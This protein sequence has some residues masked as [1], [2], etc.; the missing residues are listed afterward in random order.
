MIEKIIIAHLYNPGSAATNR[1][2]AYASGYK[3]LGNS[4]SL[5]FGC[6]GGINA[7]NLDD[8][9]VV[10]V[11]SQTHRGLSKRMARV[12]KSLYDPSR[13]A[14]QIYGTPELCLYLPK[15][16]YNIFYECTEVPFYGEKASLPSRLKEVLRLWL[17]KRSTGMMVIS[18][19]LK[20]YYSD[21]GIKNIEIVNMF[22]DANRFQVDECKR[23]DEYI[24]YCGKVSLHKD[25]VDT[26]IRAYSVF[27]KNHS[28]V[29][30]WII[31]GFESKETEKQVRGLSKELN[32][33]RDVRFLGAVAP[34]EM[35][36]LLCDAKILA[37]ARPNNIQAKYGFPTKLGEYLATGK[38]VVVTNVG[39]IG[40]FLEDGVNCRIAE[41][42]NYRDFADKLS[43][44]MDNYEL[45]LHIGAKGRE[46]TQNAF[47]C[48]EQCKVAL[49]FMNHCIC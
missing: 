48:V 3:H 10:E 43:W 36:A 4:V 40:V 39:E 8:I 44:V 20:D 6:E 30:L 22:V 19:A 37:L 38:P 24:A 42:D 35:P 26:L 16:C 2:L 15:S 41:P 18:R 9:E 5:V 45:A 28:S 23:K 49:S 29:K 46:L 32:L 7:P 17:I 31:G 12:I 14:I 34:S 13:T 33:D 21:R 25:G 11:K 27:R 1:I 47:S